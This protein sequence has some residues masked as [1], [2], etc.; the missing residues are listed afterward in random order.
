MTYN[1]NKGMVVVVSKN[2]CPNCTVV[3]TVFDDW[4]N[5]PYEEI[6]I[7]FEEN[8]DL[9]LALKEKGF[10][11]LPIVIWKD[12]IYTHGEINEFLK[13]YKGTL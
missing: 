2:H 7:E 5:I 1:D 9:L 12:K 13:D 10:Q 8:L 4:E 6:N 11:T 3:K